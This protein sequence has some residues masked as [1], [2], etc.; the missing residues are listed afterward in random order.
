MTVAAFN[1]PPSSPGRASSQELAQA[2]SQLR[3]QSGQS[4][5]ASQQPT[6][7]LAQSYNV[8]TPNSPGAPS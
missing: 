6:D 7:N 4:G 8:G 1:T 5:G 3:S 2:N